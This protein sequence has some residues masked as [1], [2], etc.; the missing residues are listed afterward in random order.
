MLRYRVIEKQIVTDGMTAN[1]A[2]ET[3]MVLQDSDPKKLFVI[4]EYNFI[5]PEGKRLGRDPDL[6]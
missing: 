4:E 6:H 5:S 2:A 1:E 3:L